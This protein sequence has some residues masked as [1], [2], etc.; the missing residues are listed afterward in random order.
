MVYLRSFIFALLIGGGGFFLIQKITED[1]KQPPPTKNA[2]PVSLVRAHTVDIKPRKPLLFLIGD[3]EAR[4]Y[5]ALTAPVE[6]PV[7]GLTA[8]E[9]ERFAKGRRLVTFDLREQ[10]LS[11]RTQE[12]AIA[13]LR[14]QITALRRNRAADQNRLSEMKKLLALAESD[15]ARNTDL[16]A[17]NVVTRARMETAEQALGQRRLDF[18]ALENQVANYANEISRL[19]QQLAAARVQLEQ[20][21]LLI[22]RGEMRAPFAGRVARVHTAV[23]ARPNRG[24]PLLDIFDP[25]RLR[26][27]VALP[28]KH[29]AALGDD[30]EVVLEENNRQMTLAFARLE[31]RV[32]PGDSSID[33]FF[34]LP[35]GDWILGGVHDVVVRLPAEDG[36]L[37]MPPDAIYQDNFVYR[38]ADDNRAYPIACQS[39]GIGR[40]HGKTVSLMRCP[41]LKNGERIVAN[42]LPNLIGSALVSVVA[43]Q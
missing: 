38:I 14:L 12:T 4:D 29:R 24:A 28:Q 32:E 27:R 5:A 33:V 42:Q 1:K 17:K 15:Y 8:R 40:N 39:V 9:G 20:V 43:E 16:F 37:A 3:V 2:E 18:V 19:E 6:A 35:A 36:L 22:E 10:E 31:P 7:L 30:L 21:L 41:Q 34:R 23:G 25:A 26:L 13:G 11:V